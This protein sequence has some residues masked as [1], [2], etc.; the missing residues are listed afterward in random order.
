MVLLSIKVTRDVTGFGVWG[1]FH[2]NT[3]QKVHHGAGGD[4][5]FLEWQSVV[6]GMVDSERVDW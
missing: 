3:L 4:N 5:A 1:I 2:V 6:V